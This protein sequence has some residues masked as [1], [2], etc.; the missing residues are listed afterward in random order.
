MYLVRE[1]NSEYLGHIASSS[2][3]TDSTTI[4]IW[5]FIEKNKVKIDDLIAIGCDD[6]VVNT[7]THRGVIRLL[8]KRL[9]VVCV[10]I[11]CK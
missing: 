5:E 7:G 3:G 6:T 8:E 9:G 1:P 4:C 11:T 10:L 2:G